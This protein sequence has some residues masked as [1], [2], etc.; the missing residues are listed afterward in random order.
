M[1]LKK[2][3]T[4]VPVD[5]WRT[6]QVIVFDWHDGPREGLCSLANPQAEFFF[7]LLDERHNPDGLDDRLF[8][9]REV[10]PGTVARTIKELRD[11]GAPDSVVWVPVWRFPNVANAQRAERFL[12]ELRTKAAPLSVVIASRDLE[13]FQGCW[14]AGTVNQPASDWFS[15]L[16]I[17]MNPGV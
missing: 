6:Q 10:S 9:I 3:L 8:R 2:V 4:A 16:S 14:D 5:Q 7:A 1:D 17:P 12:E 11:L 13:R 15:S